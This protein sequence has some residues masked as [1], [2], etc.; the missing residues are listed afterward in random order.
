M[1]KLVVLFFCLLVMMGCSDQLMEKEFIEVE[2]SM[3]Q[4]SNEYQY[5]LAKARWGDAEAYVK[6]ADCYRNGVGVKADFIGMTAMLA[7]AEQYGNSLRLEDYLKALPEN[8]SYRLMF[9][10]M[11][12][13]GKKESRQ[14]KGCCVYSCRKR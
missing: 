11:D 9:E 7:M 13:I 10:T 14:S 2:K 1:K 8:D 12:E 6:L 3:N 5:Y 4:V